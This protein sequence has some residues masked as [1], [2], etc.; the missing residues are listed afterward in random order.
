MNTLSPTRI[1]NKLARLE[2]E[3]TLLKKE[4]RIVF[5]QKKRRVAGYQEK[6]LTDAVRQT[7]DIIWRERY[8]KK[9]DR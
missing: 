3:L 4:T 9:I 5:P 8:G 2:K 7:R 1:Y 6:I